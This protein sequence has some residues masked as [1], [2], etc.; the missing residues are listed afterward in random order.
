MDLGFLKGEET[1]VATGE[2]AGRMYNM[3]AQGDGS[4]PAHPYIQVR[5]ESGDMPEA[6]ADRLWYSILGSLHPRPGAF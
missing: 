6:E 3:I 4:D 5:M 2:A 1:I